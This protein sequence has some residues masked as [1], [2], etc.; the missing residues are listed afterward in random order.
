MGGWRVQPSWGGSAGGAGL[1]LSLRVLSLKFC[2][3]HLCSPLVQCVLCV[4]SPLALL[5]PCC[6]S[7]PTG[8]KG[9]L[10]PPVEHLSVLVCV[11]SW[12]VSDVAGRKKE[13]LSVCTREN[14]CFREGLRSLIECFAV[15]EQISNFS[16]LG[17]GGC[18]WKRQWHIL[19]PL[20]QGE[21][22]G[23]PFTPHNPNRSV[24]QSGKFPGAAKPQ[25][26]PG[27]S[28]RGNK[29]LEICQFL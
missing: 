19:N 18:S 9:A 28:S 29:E 21:S 2:C 15:S 6:W 17:C 4:C 8:G 24:Q 13:K 14:C 26:V 20:G 23:H 25:R 3:K 16:I 22:N 1:E 27:C 5:L 11:G 10:P 12:R 7:D